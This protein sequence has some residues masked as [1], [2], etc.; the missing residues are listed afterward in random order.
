MILRAVHQQVRRD[1]ETS[2]AKSGKAPLQFLEFSG[3]GAITG[4]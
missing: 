2:L 3:P 4:P 1:F